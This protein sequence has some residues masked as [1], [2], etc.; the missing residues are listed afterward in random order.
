MQAINYNSNRIDF[1][2]LTI[3]NKV[4]LNQST[5]SSFI[6]AN[7]EEVSL[8]ELSDE[9]IIPV[10]TATNEPLI[11]HH[12]FIETTYLTVK[13]WFQDERVLNPS[14]RVSHP[15]KGRTPE[16][17]YKKAHELM[18]WEQTLYYERMMFCI[19]IPSISREVNGNSITLTIGG[20][21]AYNNDNIHGKRT[22]GEQHFQL[23]IGFKNLVCCNLCVSTD[24]VKSSFKVRSL[25]ELGELI[26]ELLESFNIESSIDKLRRMGSYRITESEFAQLI[27]KCRMYRY[28]PFKESVT[29]FKMEYGDQQINN[30]VKDYYHDVNFKQN[31]KGS[32]D[33]WRLYNLFTGSNK[34]SY[35]DSFLLKSVNALEF[36]DEILIH[37]NGEKVSWY[38][39]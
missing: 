38:L 3:D 25:E 34:S 22:N 13:N 19:E 27:G 33:L 31:D 26:Y 37:L 23:F 30:I 6:E 29:S 15:I 4:V 1:P 35:V 8:Q 36:M 39:K 28:A 17:K 21:K 14:I 2:A 11:S 7:T 9:H 16:A 12:E 20:V 24:G 5:P 10:F 18:P 32:I